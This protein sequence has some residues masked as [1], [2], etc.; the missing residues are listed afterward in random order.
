VSQSD[1]S[2]VSGIAPHPHLTKYYDVE[3]QRRGFV[4]GIFDQ[5]A[6]SYDRINGLMSLGSGGRYRRD[7]LRRAGLAPGNHLLD[8]AVGTGL[9]ARAASDILGNS[10]R[11]TGVDLSMGMLVEA[12][13]TLPIALVQGV[14]ERLPI[15]DACTDFVTMGYALRHVT[16]LE[17]TFREYLRV[18]KP[19][20]TLL[21]LELTRPAPK[22]LAYGLTR[23]YLHTLV[24]LIARLGPGGAE[25]RK[26]MEYFWDTIDQCVPPETIL[27]ALSSSG[28]AST[29]RDVSHHVLSEYVAVKSSG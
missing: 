20:G 3:S 2:D 28:F 10:G 14:A 13:K 29:R 24:P 7:A 22:S 8:V 15:A 9:V 21:I 6:H 27:E 23:F 4:A 12:R 26:L 17:N 19:G 1:K 11:I 25:S 18:L 5:T 16:D